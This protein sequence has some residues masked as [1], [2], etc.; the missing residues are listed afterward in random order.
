M[1]ADGK[2]VAQDYV[3]AHMWFNL[4]AV[5]MPTNLVPEVAEYQE[6]AEERRYNIERCD[7]RRSAWFILQVPSHLRVLHNDLIAKCLQIM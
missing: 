5:Y 4:A 7:R 2:G 1:Y 3:L 6:I